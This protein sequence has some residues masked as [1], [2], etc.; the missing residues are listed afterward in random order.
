MTT[1]TL[2]PEYTQTKEPN[3]GITVSG[4]FTD[5]DTTKMTIDPEGTKHIM[6][7]LSSLYSNPIP[8]VI[9]EYASNGLD[10]Q[11][12]IGVTTPV[13]LVL[14]A[15][16][17]PVFQ[18]VD[19]GIG[20]TPDELRN[21]YARYGKSTK[22]LDM[23]QVGTFGLGCKA[24]F[25][26]TPQFTVNTV[27]NGVQSVAI[28]KRGEDGVGEL[29]IVSIE[30]TDRESGT[31]V[32][33]P[34]DDIAAFKKGVAAYAYYAKPGTITID[35]SDNYASFYSEGEVFEIPDLKSYYAPKHEKTGYFV[36]SGGVAYRVRFESLAKHYH[37]LSR[38][39]SHPANMAV[40][41]EIPIGAIDL[42]PSRDDIQYTPRTNEFLTKLAD[43]VYGEI[44]KDLL[45]KV[46]KAP[47][48]LE[49]ILAARRLKKYNLNSADTKTTW[50][51]EEIPAFERYDDN[52]HFTVILDRHADRTK[53]EKQ[54]NIFTQ[55]AEESANGGIVTYYLVAKKKMTDAEWEKFTQRTRRQFL[56]FIRVKRESDSVPAARLFVFADEPTHWVTEVR[57]YKRLTVGDLEAGAKEW[58]SISA[59]KA[60]MKKTFTH[61]NP[62][63]TATPQPTAQKMTYPVL[64]IDNDGKITGDEL[65]AALLT[66]NF[67]YFKEQVERRYGENPNIEW[68]H[69]RSGSY[70]KFLL[71]KKGLLGRSIVFIAYR[72]DLS[73]L[74]KRTGFPLAEMRTYTK[75]SLA[76][77]IQNMPEV[78]KRSIGLKIAASYSSYVSYY[79]HFFKL[80]LGHKAS[81]EDAELVSVAELWYASCEWDAYLN[82]GEISRHLRDAAINPSENLAAKVI[83][84]YPL[85]VVNYF[86][87]YHRIEEHI[88][89]YINTSY[90]RFLKGNEK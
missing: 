50:H 71:E 34:V 33:I 11:T 59:R 74:F 62:P 90:N 10:A 67:L 48:R 29:T 49:A 77:A 79:N 52:K 58:R 65:P 39:T 66:E 89:H 80:V 16:L 4:N 22:T 13:N 19:H 6:Q 23:S 46:E 44:V 54:N 53:V 9:R 45:A 75:N 1:T 35:S 38:L 42:V 83:R 36:V 76:N 21:V 3:T 24:A 63:T 87:E 41:S 47:D 32:N 86:D 69:I 73:A 72:R 37:G 25:S 88:V 43:A 26:V 18:V 14:P 55:M 12:A 82:K 17:R 85:L 7:V 30:E 61:T 68:Q 60:A 20:M 40:Y 84:K 70:S 64:H 57:T 28:I 5:G 81:I 51:G 27:K 78:H 15:T 31:T 56:S 2:Y 8:A